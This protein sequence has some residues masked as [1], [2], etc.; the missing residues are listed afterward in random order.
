L[1]TLIRSDDILSDK[2][3][4]EDQLGLEHPNRTRNNW[5]RYESLNIR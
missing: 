1:L 4:P 3:R 5:I 2:L